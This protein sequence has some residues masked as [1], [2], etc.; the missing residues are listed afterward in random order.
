MANA[1]LLAEMRARISAIEQGN[2]ESCD[3]APSVSDDFAHE[4][5]FGAES[6]SP[7]EDLASSKRIHAKPEGKQPDAFKKIIALVNVSE[8]SQKAI[9]ERLAKDGFT[10][11]EIDDIIIVGGSSKMPKITEFLEKKFNPS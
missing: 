7:S 10:N 1:Q 11:D 8:R 5:M 6:E 2:N 3:K 9:R 4:N